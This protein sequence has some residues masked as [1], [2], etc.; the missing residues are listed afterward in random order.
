[1][2]MLQFPA[3]VL[4]MEPMGTRIMD[5]DTAGPQK[6]RGRVVTDPPPDVLAFRVDEGEGGGGMEE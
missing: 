5:K 2:V 6:G 3:W 4:E 1:M